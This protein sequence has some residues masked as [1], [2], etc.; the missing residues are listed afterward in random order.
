MSNQE[1]REV[2]A[3]TP[4][5]FTFNEEG[6]LVIKDDEIVEAIRAAS[7]EA[8]TMPPEEGGVHGIGISVY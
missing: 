4:D 5:Q 1:P 2:K 7:A 3:L 8:E 6:Q